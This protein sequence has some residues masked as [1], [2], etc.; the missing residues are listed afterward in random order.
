VLAETDEMKTLMA[1]G[2][3]ASSDIAAAAETTPVANEIS[4]L[5][6]VGCIS[7]CDAVMLA[8]MRRQPPKPLY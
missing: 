7:K 5:H 8:L 4:L 2:V 3:A 6:P 1:E